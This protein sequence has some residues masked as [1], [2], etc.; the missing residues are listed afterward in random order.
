MLSAVA[1]LSS[2]SLSGLNPLVS[3]AETSSY[4]Y[5]APRILPEL[6]PDQT[7]YDPSDQRLRD[8]INLLQEALNAEDVGKEEAIWTE[9]IAKWEGLN[10]PWVPDV[11]GRAYGN[12]GNARSRQGR[13]EEALGD[14]NRSIEICPWSVDPVLNRGVVLENTGR[15]DEAIADYRAVLAVAPEDPSAWNNL[16][17]ATAGLGRWEEALP[18]YERAAKLSPGFSFAYANTALAKYQLGKTNEAIKSFRTLL[19]RYPDFI[20]VRA[21]YAAALWADG[22]EAEAEDNWLRVD[23]P[24]YTDRAWLRKT[25][26]WPSKLVDAVESLMDVKSMA[27]PASR[28]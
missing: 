26:R 17:N 5:V 13:M 23:D 14:Y 3:K 8:A 15:F 25:R 2:L 6:T 20:E 1:L 4:A 22:L 19:R 24:R 12:R 21:A 10:E 7:K 28:A 16:G 27:R 9:V 11:V 18:Y